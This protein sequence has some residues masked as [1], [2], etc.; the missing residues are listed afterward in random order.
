M[1]DDSVSLLLLEFAVVFCGEG[2]FL[3]DDRFFGL[4]RCL[5]GGDGLS[6]LVSKYSCCCRRLRRRGD[7]SNRISSESIHSVFC[8]EAHRTR[9][10]SSLL[11]SSKNAACCVLPTVTHTSGGDVILLVVVVVLIALY[12]TLRFKKVVSGSAQRHGPPRRG[13]GARLILLEG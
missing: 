13:R 7:S 4:F 6:L 5:F 8:V 1:G 3:A 2:R 12:A 10:P 11:A 9:F